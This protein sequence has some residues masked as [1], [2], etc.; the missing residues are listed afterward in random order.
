MITD[1]RESYWI[2][3]KESMVLRNLKDENANWDREK[4]LSRVLDIYN[5]LYDE[6]WNRS[7]FNSI[8]SVYE[9]GGLYVD[10]DDVVVDLGA[11]VGIWG[12]RAMSAGAKEVFCFEP[13]FKSFNCLSLNCFGNMHPFCLALSDSKKLVKLPVWDT[14]DSVGSCVHDVCDDTIAPNEPQGS[15]I[16]ALTVTLNDLFDYKLFDHIDYLKIDIEG[17]EDK[18]IYSTSMDNLEKINKIS[19]EYHSWTKSSSEEVIGY[20]VRRG[21]KHKFTFSMNDG[22]KIITM[23]RR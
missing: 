20:L 21:F 5:Y 6:M 11:N 22:N 8:G 23:R 12:C 14:G 17:Q 2:P 4:Y 19:M 16:T 1:L 3:T 9:V 15:F 10:K 13:T 7:T 18:L